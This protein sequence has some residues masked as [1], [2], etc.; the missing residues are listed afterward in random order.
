MID[1]AGLDEFKS[2]LASSVKA[3]DGYIFVYD[4]NE[5]HTLDKIDNFLNGYLIPAQNSKIPLLIVGNR[6]ESFIE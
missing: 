1:T 4:M 2:V 6:F 3:R 5:I